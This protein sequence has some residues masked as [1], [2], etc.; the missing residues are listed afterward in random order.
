MLRGKDLE[1]R[2]GETANPRVCPCFSG[3]RTRRKP[4]AGH[5]MYNNKRK[6]ANIT[7]RRR[8]G[9]G[10]FCDPATGERPATR[11]LHLQE[12]N[13][14]I[15]AKII[16]PQDIM[17]LYK[18][19]DGPRAEVNGR[20]FAL[21]DD[22]WDDLFNAPLLRERLAKSARRAPETPPPRPEELLAPLGRQEVWAAGVTYWRSRTARMAESEQAADVYDRVY[23]AARPELFFK[24]TPRRVVGPGGA[25]RIRRDASWSV[26]EPEL[27][28]AV[29]A[30]GKAIGYAIGNDMSA[31]DI[32]GEN[33]LYLPQAKVYDQC[34]ALGPCLLVCGE[35][36]PADTTIRLRV[37][38]GGDAAFEG[39][40]TLAELRRSVEELV[41]WLFIDQSFPDGC[42][43]LTGAGVVP[44]DDFTLAAGDRI[45][46]AIDPIGVL[47]NHV[48]QEAA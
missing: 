17:R 21:R 35:P 29:N 47:E 48:V 9:P 26:P 31:R 46:I 11:P 18:C 15:M 13:F 16:A 34:C 30:A 36:L 37:E 42:F 1:E 44:P 4:G 45:R 12:I 7:R 2:S 27:A 10:A 28:V 6:M 43:L 32:E 3:A 33:P 19:A 38:R 25:V 39:S 8:G 5:I 40:T 14:K 23:A 22:D 41:S 24:A 20:F